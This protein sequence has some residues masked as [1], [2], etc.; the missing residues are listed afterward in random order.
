MSDSAVANTLTAMSI[1]TSEMGRSTVGRPGKA[2]DYRLVEAWP[3]V[4]VADFKRVYETSLPAGEREPTDQVLAAMRK[5]EMLCFG[6][7]EGEHLRGLAVVRRLR[8]GAQGID[9][10]VYLAVDGEYRSGG[11]GTI[12]LTNCVRSLSPKHG[13]VLEVEDTRDTNA[14]NKQQRL[15]RVKF[16]GRNGGVMV[17]KAPEYRAPDS[18]HAGQTLTMQL[19]W[20]PTN[21]KMPDYALLKAC[22][23]ALMTDGYG[24]PSAHPLVA[25]NVAR[26]IPDAKY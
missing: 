25:D 13:M 12:L 3:E 8:G 4:T 22:V 17:E 20:I 1:D 16:Y 5:G 14:S 2:L 21:T 11:T 18:E 6:A 23:A 19:M 24:L 26:V 15:D 10:L 7:M 9:F